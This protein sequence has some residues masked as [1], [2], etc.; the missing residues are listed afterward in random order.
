MTPQQT[1]ITLEGRLTPELAS[2]MDLDALYLAGVRYARRCLRG[3]PR[4]VAQELVHDAW[5]LLSTTKRWDPS[6]L[7]LERW[8]MLVL[9]NLINDLYEWDA[10]LDPETAAQYR[11]YEQGERFAETMPPEDVLVER[12]HRAE[13]A[14]HAPFHIAQI[15]AIEAAVAKHPVAAAILHEWK[16]AGCDLKPQ[17]LA[18]R[19]GL[20]VN[21]IYRAKEVIQYHAKQIRKQGAQS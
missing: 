12:E 18:D 5:I 15:E 9:R 19:L 21:Q 14:R 3:R 16:T 8:F 4:D 20:S 7:S 2:R 11:G 13:R 6:R 17:Q 10:N 1:Q